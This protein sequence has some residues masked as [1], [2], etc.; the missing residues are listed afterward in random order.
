[1]DPRVPTR[2]RILELLTMDDKPVPI[3]LSNHDRSVVYFLHVRRGDR[4]CLLDTA[5]ASAAAGLPQST[6]T[7]RLRINRHHTPQIS[8]TEPRTP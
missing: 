1:M 4:T 8:T 5:S 3:T 7:R 2:S 6:R